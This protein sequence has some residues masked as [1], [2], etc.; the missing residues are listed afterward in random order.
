MKRNKKYNRM[1]SALKMAERG[2][3]NLGVWRS[4][5]KETNYTAELVNYKTG[6][7]VE[8]TQTIANTIINIRHK[9]CIHMLGIGFDGNRHYFKSEVAIPDR[10]MYQ[11]DLS[12]YLDTEHKRFIDQ[13]FNSNHLTNVAWLAVPNGVELTEE[14]LS[15]LIDKRE[16]W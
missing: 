13:E 2:L 16:A 1:K 14:E 11:A 5:K 15:H 8:V 12:E 7:D 9:W 3:K 10:E 4:V 6:G